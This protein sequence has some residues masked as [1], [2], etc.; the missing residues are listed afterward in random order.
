MLIY[1]VEKEGIYMLSDKEKI[2]AENNSKCKILNILSY[3]MA[4]GLSMVGTISIVDFLMFLNE[5]LNVSLVACFCLNFL[6]AQV[7]SLVVKSFI[8]RID[9]KS[10]NLS[11]ETK[12][13]EEECE[14]E[15]VIMDVRKRFNSLSR[16]KQIELLNY[17][18]DNYL[19]KLKGFEKIDDLNYDEVLNLLNNMEDVELIQNNSG[20]SR[21]KVI[22]FKRVG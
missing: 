16:E 5:V 9:K 20:Y 4:I 3:A 2:I 12:M 11:L 6:L 13:L 19:Y 17:I 1:H 7:Y 18:K 22:E 14:I 15:N 21:K 8:E 10:L